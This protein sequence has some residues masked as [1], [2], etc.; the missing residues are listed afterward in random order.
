M[1]RFLVS[2]VVAACALIS[3]GAVPTA[4]SAT[5][6]LTHPTGTRLPVGTLLKAT[7]VGFSTTKEGS[8]GIIFACSSTWTGELLKNA[9]GEVEANV[10][11]FNSFGTG[12]S[13]GC[14]NPFGSGKFTASVPWC[15][16]ATA[17]MAADEFQIRGGKCTEAPKELRFTLDPECVYGRAEPL[18]GTFITDKEG[19]TTDAMLTLVEQ[20]FVKKS[21]SG[22]LCFTEYRWNVTYTMETDQS[23]SQPLYFS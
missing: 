5:P 15:M 20:A 6:E 18:K 7:N 19:G 12:S 11:G 1:S 2:C 16:R 22:L 10:N 21:G 8:G 3:L 14:T 23:I 9:S 17:A 13:E 4:A